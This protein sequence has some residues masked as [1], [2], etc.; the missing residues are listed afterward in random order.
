MNVTGHEMKLDLCA[1][2]K[3]YYVVLFP[4]YS[5]KWV[6]NMKISVWDVF[7]KISIVNLTS[8][9]DIKVN[10]SKPFGPSL[11]LSYNL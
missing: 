10:Y 4:A 2:E 5:S 1:A 3:H 9:L 11:A 8:P 7:S 6:H